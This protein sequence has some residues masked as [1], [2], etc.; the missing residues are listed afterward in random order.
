MIKKYF[1]IKKGGFTLIEILVTV[2]I[3]T[4]IF[5]IISGLFLS[6]LKTQKRALAS[7]DLI[8]EASY[9]MEYMS[10]Q[11]RMAQKSESDCVT[12]D[13]NYEILVDAESNPNG[14]KF[15]NY[16]NQCWTFF[17]G[18]DAESG[19]LKVNKG[20]PT[21]DDFLTSQN[22]EIIDFKIHLSG[23]EAND[24]KQPK[25]TLL[26]KIKGRGERIENMPEIIVQTT[27]SERNLDI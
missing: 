4:S 3:F 13:R 15:K 22:L 9:I 23:D 1:K 16:N 14:V 21:E 6:A 8:K 5:S 7:Q 27:V 18:E 12:G 10:R 26:F 2:A 19:R 11:L 24:D 20:V 25:L 17:L